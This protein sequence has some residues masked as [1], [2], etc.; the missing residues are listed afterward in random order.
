MQYFSIDL[1]CTGLDPDNHQII[2][3]GAVFEDTETLECN[4]F[5]RI[6]MHTE[7]TGQAYAL[8]M[9]NRILQVLAGIEKADNK[10]E[11]FNKNN[12][13]SQGQLLN[14]FYDFIIKCGIDPNKD[15]SVTINVAGKNFASFDA[16][17][18]KKIPKW[19]KR[20]RFSQRILDPGILYVNW[21]EDERL[22][23]L[24]DCKER[25]GLST[26]VTHKAIEDAMDVVEVLRKQ[27]SK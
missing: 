9:N 3:F 15:K 26:N 2:E 27:Y 7:Y 13:V 11:Y 19:S 20:I 21:R 10:L 16:L 17:F 14:D 6:V 1:E 25:A 12:I 22:P 23:S 18:L 24:S 5:E 4:S 8:N